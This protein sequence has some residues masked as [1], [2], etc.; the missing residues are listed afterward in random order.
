MADNKHGARHINHF[1]SIRSFNIN[2]A[3]NGGMPHV[4]EGCRGDD[5]AFFCGIAD[6]IDGA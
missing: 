3:D 2:T 5:A 1:A 4:N 6:E